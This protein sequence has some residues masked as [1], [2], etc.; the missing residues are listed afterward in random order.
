MVGRFNS[1]YMRHFVPERR[2]PMI[3]FPLRMSCGRVHRKQV[4]ESYAEQSDAGHADR[5]YDKVF[6]IRI[7]FHGDRLVR[8]ETIPLGIQ[9][10]AFFSELTRVIL[11]YR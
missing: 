7:N 2:A 8:R 1:K 3:T 11:Q 9:V 10:D 4:T 6:V 5:P